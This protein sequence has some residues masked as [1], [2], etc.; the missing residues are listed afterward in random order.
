MWNHARHLVAYDGIPAARA[1]LHTLNPRL[2]PKELAYIV[3]D[4]RDDMVIVDE[5]LLPLWREVE[6]QVR[7]RHVIVNGQENAAHDIAWDPRRP[8]SRRVAR[9][10]PTRPRRRRSATLPGP[11]AG[12]GM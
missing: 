4:A 12:R 10:A 7:P 2:S 6:A 9:R 3:A 11:P 1:M 8:R 5:D